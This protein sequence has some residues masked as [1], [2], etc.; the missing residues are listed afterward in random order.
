M[1]S[2][3]VQPTG[4]VTR[5]PIRGASGYGQLADGTAEPTRTSVPNTLETAT[6]RQWQQGPLQP[7]EARPERKLK[8]ASGPVRGSALRQGSVSN[9]RR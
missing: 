9:R 2:N 3:H 8:R 4:P 6:Q 1:L 5:P 7:A